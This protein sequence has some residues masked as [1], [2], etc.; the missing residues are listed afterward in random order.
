MPSTEAQLRAS[1]KYAE[2]NKS[3]RADMDRQRYQRNL[4]AERE[5]R[6]LYVQQNK[7]NRV[8]YNRQWEGL[9]HSKRPWVR[10]YH[11]CKQRAKLKDAPFD[12]TV[13]Y[14]ESIWNQYCPVLGIEMS[15]GKNKQTD[16]SPS[17]DRIDPTKGYVQGNVEVI[18][19]KAN[20]MKN[21]GSLSELHMLVE[22][23]MQR[24]P[25]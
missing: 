11:S 13:E 18:S 24:L 22:Y 21:N 5:K 20:R 3:K 15:C 12:L 19:L 8:E 10:A 23:L 9:N 2:N 6:R 7:D 25:S 14:V 4:E 1:K 16:N 17:L